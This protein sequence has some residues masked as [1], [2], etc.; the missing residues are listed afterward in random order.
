MLVLP[1]EDFLNRMQPSLL[2]FLLED[3]QKLCELA[4]FVVVLQLGF[5]FVM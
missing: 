3:M 5:D 2:S 1:V 4:D